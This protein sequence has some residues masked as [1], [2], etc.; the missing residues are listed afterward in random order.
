MSC[1]TSADTV[2]S[3]FFDRFKDIILLYNCLN[4]KYPLTIR[5]QPGYEVWISNVN[6]SCVFHRGADWNDGD[7]NNAD[8]S[9]DWNNIHLGIAGYTLDSACLMAITSERNS[10]INSSNELVFDLWK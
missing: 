1:R 3:G 10:E 7:G 2:S 4:N 5:A 9:I 6:S 8:A